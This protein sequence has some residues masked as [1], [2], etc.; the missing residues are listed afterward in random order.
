[1]IR[2]LD[3]LLENNL[4]QSEEFLEEKVAG[5]NR[6]GQ[7]KALYAK[8]YLKKSKQGKVRYVKNPGKYKGKYDPA[9]YQARKKK[10]KLDEVLTRHG[11]TIHQ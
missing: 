3:H 5:A 6:A 7:M 8:G 10:K 9:K 11:V 4:I 1:M 2:S